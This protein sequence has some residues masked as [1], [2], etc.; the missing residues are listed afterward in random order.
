MFLLLFLGFSLI[1]YIC[2]LYVQF[3][4]SNKNL[5]YKKK[6]GEKEYEVRGE[7]HKERETKRKM[8]LILKRKVDVGLQYTQHQRDA[9]KQ[10][11]SFKAET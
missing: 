10:Q 7:S 1:F 3:E 2:S 4:K 6:D 11:H 9:A 8:D 5:N